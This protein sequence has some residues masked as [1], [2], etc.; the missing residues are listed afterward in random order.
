[1]AHESAGIHLAGPLLFNDLQKQNGNFPNLKIYPHDPESVQRT[2]TLFY[3]ILKGNPLYS[4]M[5]GIVSILHCLED[6]SVL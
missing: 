4:S 6:S 5:L 2:I 1:E 3:G